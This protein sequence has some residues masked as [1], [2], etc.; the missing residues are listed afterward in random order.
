MV[1]VPHPNHASEFAALA[2]HVRDVEPGAQLLFCPSPGNWGDSIINAGTR[3]F[4]DHYGWAY[5][6][7]SRE[8]LF[9]HPGLSAAHVLVGGGG[10]WCE[11]WH[12]T[13]EL[14][15]RLAPRVR[16]LT[17]LPTTFGPVP[18]E[19]VLGS[20]VTLFARDDTYS[21]RQQPGA[22]FCH[23]MAFHYA[24]PRVEREAAEVQLHAFRTDRERN[25]SIESE[26][27]GERQNRDISL[28]D[29][30]LADPRGLYTAL[31]SFSRVS[32]DRLHVAIASAQIGLDVELFPSGY[33]KIESVYDSSIAGT[34]PN[35]RLKG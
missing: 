29:K 11:F 1:N 34:F 3:N 33:P 2:G 17:V 22:T 6:E 5:V 28:E 26:V 20:N 31:S 12:T 19:P 10:G 21:L 15:E 9:D 8:K 35:V 30:G 16:H 14:V 7:L 27:P 18:Q 13:P 24:P 32:T 25:A 4:L 23:D